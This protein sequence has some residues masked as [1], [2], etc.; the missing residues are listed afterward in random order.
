[1]SE[2]NIDKTDSIVLSDQLNQQNHKIQFLK[3]VLHKIVVKK[4]LSKNL[5]SKLL[6]KMFQNM[7]KY[8]ENLQTNPNPR[9]RP[10][11]YITR[12]EVIVPK[13]V[14]SNLKRSSSMVSSKFL[15]YKLTPEITINKL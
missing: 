3:N 13:G 15:T 9:L 12:A 14:N 7:V 2:K 6:L 1:M 10:S 5:L 8:I 11:S 4:L